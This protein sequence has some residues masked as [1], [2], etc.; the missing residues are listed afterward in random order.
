MGC[1]YV[2]HLV[3]LRHAHIKMR[4]HSQFASAQVKEPDTFIPHVRH[5]LSLFI[6]VMQAEYHSVGLYRAHFPDEV[7]ARETGGELLRLVVVLP[8]AL[9]VVIQGID[10]SG[11]QKTR[12]TPAAT[13]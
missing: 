9:D 1:E 13:Q 7:Q 5:E 2:T 4:H 8:Q 11:S 3:Y 12:L 10:A 6:R